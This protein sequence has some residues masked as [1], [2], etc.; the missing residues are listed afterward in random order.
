[1]TGSLSIAAL[2]DPRQLKEMIAIN[3]DPEQQT[4][5]WHS[6]AEMFEADLNFAKRLN[7]TVFCYRKTV[8][9]VMNL[10]KRANFLS[11]YSLALVNRAESGES[12][13]A[14]LE[15]TMRATKVAIELAQGSSSYRIYLA[16]YENVKIRLAQQSQSLEE[17]NQEIGL[18]KESI[19]LTD[20]DDEISKRSYAKLRQ[21]LF[22]RAESTSKITHAKKTLEIF[23]RNPIEWFDSADRYWFA[24]LLQNRH[25]L[26]ESTLDLNKAIDILEEL[27]C[28]ESN[29]ENY[30]ALLIL[31]DNC[32]RMRARRTDCEEDCNR[33]IA[34]L[35]N[36][37]QRLEQRRTSTIHDLAI[38]LRS[39]A[40]TLALRYHMKELDDLPHDPIA[41]EDDLERAIRLYK[42]ATRLSPNDPMKGNLLD[43]LD[44]ALYA[45]YKKNSS[46]QDLKD[47]ILTFKDA[48]SLQSMRFHA[49]T[50]ASLDLALQS[51]IKESQLNLDWNL[52]LETY[53]QGATCLESPVHYRIMTADDDE[54]CIWKRDPRRAY[55]LFEM[56]I[57]LL[58]ALTPRSLMLT[59][60]HKN[61]IIFDEVVW[62]AVFVCLKT[63]DDVYK[64]IRLAEIE[65]GIIANLQHSMNT[66]I[67][68]LER[69]HS[70][71]AKR[72]SEVRGSLGRI[73]LNWE[74]D[75]RS[76]FDN[77]NDIRSLNKE[78]SFVIDEIKNLN[79]FEDF[80]SCSK[81]AALTIVTKFEPIVIFSVSD[82]RS[83]ALL[84][85]FKELSRMHLSKLKYDDMLHYAQQFLEAINA[86]RMSQYVESRRKMKKLLEWLW[87]V[88]ISNVLQELGFTKT[89][90]EWK[91]WSQVWWVR[92][93]VFSMFPLHAADYHAFESR[94]SALDRVISFYTTTIKSLLFA[95]RFRNAKANDSTKSNVLV[96]GM[97]KTPAQDNLSVV[98]QEMDELAQLFSVAPSTQ[99][100]T[101][102]DLSDVYSILEDIDVF[103]FSGHEL[104]CAADPSLSCMLLNDWQTTSLTVT[105]LRSLQ[106]ERGQFTF[107][108]A[109]HSASSANAGLR[110]LDESIHI[111]S[112]FQLAG[113]R[114]IVATLWY[115]YGD[116]AVTI[117]KNLY[118]AMQDETDQ[119]HY[120][121]AASALH[122]AIRNLRDSLRTIS[123]IR[124]LDPDDPLARAVYIYTEAWRPS[125]ID[126]SS[127]MKTSPRGN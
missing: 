97:P 48:L 46:P 35:E 109:C 96:V 115:A 56:T 119:L 95:R 42:E 68:E 24:V 79:A 30:E 104:S 70:S 15:L 61:L 98:E 116:H 11:H 47:I 80:L 66:D 84:I 19:V 77:V 93:D 53:E 105:S 4:H 102:P 37:F 49:Q 118:S 91:K 85:T 63:S 71:L 13:E 29:Q 114:R 126:C 26:T 45:K 82:I 38:C 99:F 44:T 57:M 117:A 88:V 39:K 111:S 123:D 90:Q 3:P 1:M 65:R 54:K 58:P 16:N 103:H 34:L 74:D 50:L 92:A 122:H 100:K 52:A 23:E 113:F 120:D 62:S 87:D 83:D 32:L 121:W 59:D 31:L 40:S 106:I 108:S 17:M 55:R 64:A 5:L 81:K 7:M 76:R 69:E 41:P 51:K 10:E 78:L 2:R 33:S 14:N 28:A 25:L 107:L 124:K 125:V 60:Q 43:T 8:D 73:S 75:S 86:S 67:S 101:N 9:L 27:Y 36:A 18:L 20:E 72:L 22:N 12:N 112:S 6:A 110:L 21:E 94:E 89:S 127:L